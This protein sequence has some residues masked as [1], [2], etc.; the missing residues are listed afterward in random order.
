M[1]SFFHQSSSKYQQVTQSLG[2]FFAE[3]LRFHLR[4]TNTLGWVLE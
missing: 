3:K 2:G 1:F 4:M